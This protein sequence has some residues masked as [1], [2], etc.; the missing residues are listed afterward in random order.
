MS[1]SALADA[2]LEQLREAGIDLRRD[3]A[4]AM[5]GNRVQQLADG[6]G[7]APETALGFFDQSLVRSWAREAAGQLHDEQPGHPGVLA[8]PGLLVPIALIA[9]SVAALL[10]T[11]P[12]LARRAAEILTTY[13]PILLAGVAVIRCPPQLLKEC[14]DAMPEPSRNVARRLGAIADAQRRSG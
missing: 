12:V 11:E 5:I 9:A 13:P 10:D 4:E 1:I 3:S 6:L 7:L 8:I 2:Y 14:A